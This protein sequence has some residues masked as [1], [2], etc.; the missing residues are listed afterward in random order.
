MQIAAYAEKEPGRFRRGQ[1][2]KVNLFGQN[3]DVPARQPQAFRVDMNAGMVL[4]THLH[5]VD[6]FQVFIAGSGKI[7]RDK[8][9]MV[10]V[11]Y[12]DHHTAYGPLVAGAQGM[13]YL[14]LRSLTDAGMVKLSAP[15]LRSRLAPSRRRHRAS[16]PVILSIPPVLRHRAE[17][18]VE[19]AFEAKPG[20]DGMTALVYRLGGGMAAQG[21][22]TAGSGGYYVVV[23]NG[24]LEMAGQTLS[25]WSM[26]FVEAGEE[27]P[28][29][30]AAPE[31]A[32]LLV[33]VFP[34][35]DAWMQQLGRP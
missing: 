34:S 27:A 19:P 18:S 25:P 8:A 24:A 30:Q 14:T 4:D 22:A 32:E 2:W 17:L 26:L 21:P 33:A 23:M 35:Q 9:D 13:S 6:Q 28:L 5:V 3:S 7:G 12:A 11:H 15:D 29:F 10:M 20:D 31:G 1:G 16:P